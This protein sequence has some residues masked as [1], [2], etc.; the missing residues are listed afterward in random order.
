MDFHGSNPFD[1]GKARRDSPCAQEAALHTKNPYS[2]LRL[3]KVGSIPN[4]PE[5][6][7]DAPADVPTA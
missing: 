5:C 1:A 4:L 6:I 7:L 2:F 3:V